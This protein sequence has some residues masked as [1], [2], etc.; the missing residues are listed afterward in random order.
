MGELGFV[1]YGTPSVKFKFARVKVC[2]VVVHVSTE[3]MKFGLSS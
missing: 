2:N 3:R 1:N